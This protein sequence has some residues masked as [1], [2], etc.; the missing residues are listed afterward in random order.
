M[1]SSNLLNAHKNLDMK[2]FL[3]AKYENITNAVTAFFVEGSDDYYCATLSLL[4]S[5][6]NCTDSCIDSVTALRQQLF[7]S[8]H[9]TSS[10]ALSL[11][12]LECERVFS[13]GVRARHPHEIQPFGWLRD[14]ASRLRRG[15]GLVGWGW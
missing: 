7:F 15:G 1:S 14:S 12:N 8:Q 2:Y 13:A 4:S 5:S 6:T 3:H 10:R 11:Q 9:H